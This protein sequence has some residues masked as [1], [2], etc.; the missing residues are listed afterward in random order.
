MVEK[1]QLIA[2]VQ[3]AQSGDSHA[4]M[5]IY[6]TFQDDIYYFILKTVTDDNHG[7]LAEVSAAYGDQI[8]VVFD[9]FAFR[10]IEEKL[11]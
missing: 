7:R 6:E 2:M 4:T 8:N 1:E 3:G 5:Q 9:L 10:K 11:C